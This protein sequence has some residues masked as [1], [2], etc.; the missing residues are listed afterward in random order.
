MRCDG[1]FDLNKFQLSQVSPQKKVTSGLSNIGNTCFM[2]AALQCLFSTG[3]LAAYFLSDGYRTGIDPRKS[4]VSQ[5]I[6]CSPGPLALAFGDLM[7]SSYER[8]STGDRPVVPAAFKKIVERRAPQF[9]GYDQQDAQE[10]L[11]FL[12]D[13][14]HDDL[15][16]VAVKP[17]FEYRDEDYDVLSNAQKALVSW[18]R[19]YS[20]NNSVISD[21]FQGQLESTVTCTRCNT[22]SVTYDAFWGI[23]LPIPKNDFCS[24]EHCF[25]EYSK[26]ELLGEDEKYMCS[27]CKRRERCTKK[28]KIYKLPT[29]LVIHLK[30]FLYTSFSRNKLETDIS[31]P[32]SRL[33]LDEFLSAEKGSDVGQT[34]ELYATINHGGGLGGGHYTATCLQSGNWYLK[35][36]GNSTESN[37][38]TNREGRSPYVLFYSVKRNA[39]VGRL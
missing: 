21:L 34:Y 20:Y 35:N 24:L 11:T 33:A 10:F 22:P 5:H 39:P 13:G 18:N 32:C 17:K 4:A 23:S 7:K 3:P 36:D 16:R 2:A 15:S 30:R 19:T 29:I 27:N 1:E 14:L 12:L 26:E 31:Y 6:Q 37:D 28:I 25:R 9:V 8:G 38:P